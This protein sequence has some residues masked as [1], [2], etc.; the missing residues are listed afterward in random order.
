VGKETGRFFEELEERKSRT[1]IYYVWV[2][3][4]DILVETGA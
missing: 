2:G 3:G 4:E 1:K